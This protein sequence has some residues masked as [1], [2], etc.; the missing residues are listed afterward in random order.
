MTEGLI[1]LSL[2]SGTS[3]GGPALVRG[4]NFKIEVGPGTY[5]LVRE[6]PR[7]VAHLSKEN[8]RYRIIIE[9]SGHIENL[10]NGLDQKTDGKNM[11]QNTSQLVLGLLGTVAL[12]LGAIALI[13]LIGGINAANEAYAR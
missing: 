4:T 11:G 7:C 3:T 9:V 10:N 13:I 12:L 5:T 6:T 1:G 8:E 2:H